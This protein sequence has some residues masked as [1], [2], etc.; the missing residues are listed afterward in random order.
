MP[1]P[2]KTDADSVAVA[3][4]L[5]SEF[6]EIASVPVHLVA[7]TQEPVPRTGRT[8]VWPRNMCPESVRSFVVIMK[9]EIN[10]D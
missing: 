6:V 8:H 4:G 2:N 10:N 1:P 5:T 9:N 3:V 7:E